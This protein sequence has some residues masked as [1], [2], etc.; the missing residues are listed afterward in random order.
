MEDYIEVSGL[1]NNDFVQTITFLIIWFVFP[2]LTL[3]FLVIIGCLIV[4][5][6][7]NRLSRRFEV[8][9]CIKILGF[10]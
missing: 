2:L 9:Y 5:Q 8:L 1:M 3:V 6:K 7:L 10:N 4:T